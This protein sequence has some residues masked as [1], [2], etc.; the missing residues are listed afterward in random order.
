MTPSGRMWKHECKT[1]DRYPAE[2]GS[3]YK[4]EWRQDYR[5]ISI[6]VSSYT[7]ELYTEGFRIASIMTRLG[8]NQWLSGS[9]YQDARLKTKLRTFWQSGENYELNCMCDF[10]SSPFGC[11]RCNRIFAYEV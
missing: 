3:E 10:S 4:R 2:L 11:C 1:L 7:H 8:S 9:S 5:P 6:G